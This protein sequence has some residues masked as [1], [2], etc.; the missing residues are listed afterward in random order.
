MYPTTSICVLALDFDIRGTCLCVDTDT[1]FGVVLHRPVFK[2]PLVCRNMTSRDRHVKRPMYEKRY[3]VRRA[4]AH[5]PR[6]IKNQRT[7]AEG[8]E[9]R[10]T[11]RHTNFRFPHHRIKPSIQRHER[12][13]GLYSACA[14]E[15]A[16]VCMRKDDAAE[17]GLVPTE[18]TCPLLFL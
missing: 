16:K 13:F 5:G 14:V 6:C 15:E 10:R 2:L 9:E 8:L 17:R 18:H 12:A 1:V 3:M 4:Q 7:A 11:Q